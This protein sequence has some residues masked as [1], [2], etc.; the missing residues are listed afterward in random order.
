MYIYLKSEPGLWT[1]GYYGPAGNFQPESDH[2]STDSAAL[3]VNFLNGGNKAQVEELADKVAG[4][5]SEIHDLKIS[6]GDVRASQ[7][8]NYY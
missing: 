8:R 1:V 2:D 5:E 4:L 6:I 3:R 7:K